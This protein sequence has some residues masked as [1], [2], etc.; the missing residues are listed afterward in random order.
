MQPAQFNGPPRTNLFI[1]I[2]WWM[3]AS[4]HALLLS[5]IAV[6]SIGL[7]QATCNEG[8]I[9]WIVLI[10]AA[11]LACVVSATLIWLIS[12][13]WRV[14]RYSSLVRAISGWALLLAIFMALVGYAV[15]A[16]DARAAC[17]V[18]GGYRA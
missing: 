18:S 17:F 6:A 4:V 5:F 1:K 3:V 2:L 8:C 14:G 9:Y 13:L 12:R 16:R 10:G 11:V 7:W 15:L